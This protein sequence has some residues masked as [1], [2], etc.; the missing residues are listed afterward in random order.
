MS[1]PSLALYVLGVLVSASAAL[2]NIESRVYGF[3]LIG[4]GLALIVA[5]SWISGGLPS[6]DSCR[7]CCGD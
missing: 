6:A 1:K 5:A 3:G 4:V 7:D 2:L